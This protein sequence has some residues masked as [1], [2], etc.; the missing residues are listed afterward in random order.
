MHTELG[1]IEGPACCSV[2]LLS[3]YLT[4]VSLNPLVVVFFHLHRY[5]D[6]MRVAALSVKGVVDGRCGAIVTDIA[7]SV[8]LS[9]EQS[10]LWTTDVRP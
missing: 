7:V 6:C 8:M 10:L 5:S 4:N 3:V 2:V 9:E 1:N